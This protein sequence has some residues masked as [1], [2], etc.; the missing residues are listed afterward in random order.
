MRTG[1]DCNRGL[2]A[3]GFQNE[4]FF[5]CLPLNKRIR[6]FASESNFN[7]F[8]FNLYQADILSSTLW[9]VYMKQIRWQKKFIKV[10][11]YSNKLP[12]IGGYNDTFIQKLRLAKFQ[13][14]SENFEITF[15]YANEFNDIKTIQNTG[16][17]YLLRID[18]SKTVIS[19]KKS[20]IWDVI[21]STWV[22]ILLVF[23]VFV[24]KISRIINSRIKKGQSK[25]DRQRER[26]N[27]INIVA[28]HDRLVNGSFR[29]QLNA[30]KYYF[31]D[32]LNIADIRQ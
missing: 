24:F 30:V 25:S 21:D 18:H 7:S 19:R 29:N 17:R 20:T 26:L 1:T 14:E 22:V 12:S 13:D 3:M 32:N 8:G 4:S 5:F 11:P 28:N 9:S 15:P 23:Q 31:K 6:L 10:A 27:I 16:K 2:E